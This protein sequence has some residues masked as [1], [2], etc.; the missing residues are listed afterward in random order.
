MKDK[1]VKLMA[2]AAV[3][4]VD[5]KV[6]WCLWGEK[7]IPKVILDEIKAKKNK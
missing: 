3:D 5:S 7:E 2:K 1:L 4:T 6:S